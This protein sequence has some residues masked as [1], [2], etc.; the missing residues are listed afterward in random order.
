M[1]RKYLFFAHK[2]TEKALD[3]DY[4]SVCVIHS[5]TMRLF[6]N[7]KRISFRENALLSSRGMVCLLRVPPL[8][9]SVHPVKPI[10]GCGSSR[11]KGFTR[12]LYLSLFFILQHSPMSI[13]CNQSRRQCKEEDYLVSSQCANLIRFHRFSAIV[14]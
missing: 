2:H 14:F 6:S 7:T 1:N 5:I 11:V 4:V 12:K 8:I 10:K 13:M 9:Y 3:F